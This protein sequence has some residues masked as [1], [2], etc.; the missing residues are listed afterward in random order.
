MAASAAPSF[1]ATGITDTNPM[2]TDGFEFVEY[3]APDPAALEAEIRALRPDGAARRVVRAQARR[4]RVW[5]RRAYAAGPTR[6][7]AKAPTSPSPKRSRSRIPGATFAARVT[8]CP[9]P[10]H[11][12]A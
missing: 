5:G 6:A 3:T 1:V 8:G 2:G 10:S 11:T 7:C 4:D 12:I 9:S